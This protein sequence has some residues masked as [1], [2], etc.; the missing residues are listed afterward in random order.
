MVQR[1]ALEY[2]TRLYAD[3]SS[4]TWNIFKYCLTDNAATAA[5]KVNQVDNNTKILILFSHWRAA[6]KPK[7]EIWLC[8]APV[9]L[10]FV[11]LS[12]SI[13]QIA[14]PPKAAKE[15]RLSDQY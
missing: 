6:D 3:W 10:S 14:R 15:A 5:K 7:A 2:Q 1:L 11:S 8:L 12:V 13:C 9:T 4:S